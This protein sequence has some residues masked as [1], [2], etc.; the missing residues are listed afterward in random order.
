VTT[1]T[2]GMKR[3]RTIRS[4]TAAGF[5]EAER[6]FLNFQAKNRTRS[7][8]RSMS[9]SV[10]ESVCWDE[11]PTDQGTSA[12]SRFVLEGGFR[13]F[14]N[15]GEVAPAVRDEASRTGEAG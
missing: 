9:R 5:R 3:P 15:D 4:A 6:R 11:K 7:A 8:Q 14:R 12:R 1:V 10:T 13:A 2:L